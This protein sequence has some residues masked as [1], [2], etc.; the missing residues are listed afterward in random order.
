MQLKLSF[1][2]LIMCPGCVCRGEGINTANDIGETYL[3]F[4]AFHSRPD[5]VKWLIDKGAECDM[6]VHLPCSCAAACSARSF[7]GQHE[8]KTELPLH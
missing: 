1:N 5:L 6:Q 2:L 7:F 4:A 8:Q 3:H